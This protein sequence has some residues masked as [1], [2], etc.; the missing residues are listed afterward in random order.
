[1]ATAAKAFD[2]AELESADTTTVTLTNPVTGDDIEGVTIEIYGPDSDVYKSAQNKLI[3]KRTDYKARHRGKD[4]P[5]EE[6]DRQYRQMIVACTKSIN[7]FVY[8]GKPV[9]DPAE[10][11]ALP[12]LGWIFEQVAVA[13]NDR[14]NFI[15]A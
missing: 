9:T 11:Y 5:Q 4:M 12:N 13:M 14:A 10:V 8:K 2:F 7:G 6:S 15:K 3:A 1:M